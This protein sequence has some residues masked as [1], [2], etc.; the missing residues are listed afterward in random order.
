[1]ERKNKTYVSLRLAA[2]IRKII[3]DNKVM[4]SRNRKKGIE[5][6]SLISSGRQ[7]EA[8]SGL[9]ITIIQKV[10][11][12]K[13]D[14]QF[15]T[16]ITLI[17]SLGISLSKFA[18]LYDKLTDADIQDAIKQMEESRKIYARVQARKKNIGRGR[19]RGTGK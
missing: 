4:H 14:L 3:S 8:A 1:M 16:L 5:D 6:L 10:M 17:E 18:A 13:R 7:L 2:C 9:S 11:A 12:G 15:T 19:K